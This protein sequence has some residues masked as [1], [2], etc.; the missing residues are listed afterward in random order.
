[1]FTLSVI[2]S[3]SSYGDVFMYFYFFRLLTQGNNNKAIYD[4]MK[5]DRPC[6]IL[7]LAFTTPTCFDVCMYIQKCQ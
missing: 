4:P 3:S 5:N 7:D 2:L 6:F 1:M